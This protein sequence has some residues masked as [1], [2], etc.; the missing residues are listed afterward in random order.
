MSLRGSRIVLALALIG[1]ESPPIR[2]LQ[3]QPDTVQDALRFAMD[4][5]GGK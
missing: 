4:V 5:I 2:F 3:G 1:V